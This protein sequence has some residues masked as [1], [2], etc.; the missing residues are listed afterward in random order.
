[1]LRRPGFSPIFSSPAAEASV[2]SLPLV[3]LLLAGL[4]IALAWSI[5]ASTRGYGILMANL[6]FFVS[7][8]AFSYIM[9]LLF[10]ELRRW[11]ADAGLGG[12]FWAGLGIL[13]LCFFYVF[14]LLPP[15]GFQLFLFVGLALSFHHQI[16]QVQGFSLQYL[17]R[18]GLRAPGWEKLERALYHLLVLTIVFLV[19]LRIEGKASLLELP[20]SVFQSALGLA[21]IFAG[22]IMALSL[23]TARANVNRSVFLLRLWLF[24][25]VPLSF[26]A[27]IG[28]MVSHGAE[29][30]FLFRQMYGR[31]SFSRASQQKWAAA[32]IVG[33]VCLLLMFRSHGGLP[34]SPPSAG[35]AK[36]IWSGLGALSFTL[37][38]GHYYLDRVL[39]RM[40]CEKTRAA[41]GPLL[42]GA[43]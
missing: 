35:W 20:E 1:M 6:L 34:V 24:P 39:F 40:T 38:F 23:R 41:V 28:A 7:H 32:A 9:L 19:W 15:L 12:P 10:P 33:V 8:N 18:S 42:S 13:F 37:T 29:Y 2:L 17:Q 3:F 11:A 14:Y 31:S 36:A 27:S 43:R 5:L 26:F 30:A 4:E 22:S 25:A 21:F 16:M